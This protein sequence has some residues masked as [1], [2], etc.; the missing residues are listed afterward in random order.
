[1]FKKLRESAYWKTAWLILICGGILIAFSKLIGNM[2]FSTGLAKINETLVPVY[3]GII[4]AFLVCPIYNM[5]VKNLYAKKPNLSLAK[6]MATVVSLVLIVGFVALMA[7]FLI[8]QVVTSCVT[9]VDTLPE[10]LDATSKWL[11]EHVSA[12]PQL[13]DW[14]GQLSQ[15]NITK[16]VMWIQKNIIGENTMEVATVV[17]S[18]V[19]TAVNS[20]INA[21]VGILIMIYVL[22]YKET[23]FAM[24]KKIIAATC[25]DE[26][27]DDWYEFGEIFNETFVG[28]IVGRIIDSAIIGVLTYFV[29]LV[30][31][32]PFA[33]MIAMIVGVTNVI[34]FFGPFI[35]AIP[36]FLIIML[37]NPVAA[38]EFLII[39][40]V[41]QQIDGNIIG[42]KIVGDAIGIG[43]FWVLIAVLIGGG[44]FG[45]AGMVFGVP[46]FAVVYIYVNKIT[47][48]NLAKK[49]KAVLTSDYY[50]LEKYAI[51]EKTMESKLDE[52]KLKEK[53]EKEIKKN[54]KK[55][56]K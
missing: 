38:F 12:I 22:N 52:I 36:S 53:K 46:V 23:L 21:F 6:A 14:V 2:Q 1:M 42:P 10:R 19:M 32:I 18:G 44:L 11:T 16:A 55:N 29:L 7:Y 47:T 28:F 13:G 27:R 4:C 33:S 5:I 35:G 31:K 25:T 48:K 24:S 43:S 20:V 34:P 49:G 50:T 15:T 37:E 30:F 41:I 8:P 9:L 26:K 17:S 45:F 3:V 39:I 51:D 56:K 54:K 40:L